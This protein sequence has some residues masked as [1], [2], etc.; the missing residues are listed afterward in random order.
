MALGLGGSPF[1]GMQVCFSVYPSFE[2]Q[3]TQT[4]KIV[5]FDYYAIRA[6][7]AF[8]SLGPILSPSPQGSDS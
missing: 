4:W 8:L 7:D 1:L 6:I 5:T 2:L 3:L